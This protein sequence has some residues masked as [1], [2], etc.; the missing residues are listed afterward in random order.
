MTKMP[1]YGHTT[2]LTAGGMRHG[3]ARVLRV[4]TRRSPVTVVLSPTVVALRVASLPCVHSA[5]TSTAAGHYQRSSIHTLRSRSTATILQSATAEPPTSS[6]IDLGLSP[7]GGALKASG[8]QVMGSTAS[9][10]PLAGDLFRRASRS[11]P[12]HA[13][14]RPRRRCRPA[15]TSPEARRP[16]APTLAVDPAQPSLAIA[17]GPLPI[18]APSP[19]HRAVPQRS[20]LLLRP[21]VFAEGRSATSPEPCPPRSICGGTS[22]L[23]RH[24]P[25]KPRTPEC[26]GR[27][28][29]HGLSPCLS[30]V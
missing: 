3:R 24:D 2:V 29:R 15:S 30:G 13:A 26:R 16:L 8:A 1:S 21:R 4:R 28:D 10:T 22:G 6:R 14:P 17:A 7:G 12:A 9:P 20:K 11:G 19:P 18:P 23:Q 27:R 5:V 25:R